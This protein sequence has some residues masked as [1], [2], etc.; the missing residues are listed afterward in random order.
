MCM[1]LREREKRTVALCPFTG[2][3]DDVYTF[4]E[5][6]SIRAAV[7][8]LAGQLEA[9]IYGERVRLMRRMLYDGPERLSLGMGV[10]LED[11][12]YR[13]VALESWAHQTAT[14]ERIPE[15]R[16]ADGAEP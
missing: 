14:L 12:M 2:M 13:I 5:G 16:L 9:Q 8:P 4:A 11:G 7:Y 10:K 3:D 15:G 6:T 1:R